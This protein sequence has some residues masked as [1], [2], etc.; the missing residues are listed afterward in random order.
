MTIVTDLTGE[1]SDS[2]N[3]K[4]ENLS[5]PECNTVTPNKI[6]KPS[7][8]TTIEKAIM[9]GYSSGRL[10]S[11]D[12]VHHKNWDSHN[13]FCNSKFI[14]HPKDSFAAPAYD[15]TTT[16]PTTPLPYSYATKLPMVS[17]ANN[18]DNLI[19]NNDTYTSTPFLYSF[20]SFMILVWI[21]TK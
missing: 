16:S 17:V 12:G 11:S 5:S 21:I 2:D 1:D 18:D 10:K 14:Y 13:T 6:L 15:T 20:S 3:N 9:R 4:D 7:V 8:H 19:D